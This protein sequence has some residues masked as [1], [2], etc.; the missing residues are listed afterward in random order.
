MRLLWQSI[1]K[2]TELGAAP[3]DGC[4]CDFSGTL[5][6]AEIEG[7]IEMR[8]EKKRNSPAMC[9]WP[10]TKHTDLLFFMTISK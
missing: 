3:G 2:R 9:T 10:C 8:E 7:L 5:T 1:K 6:E 4:Y